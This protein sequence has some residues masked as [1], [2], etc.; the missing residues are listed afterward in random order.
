MVTKVFFSGLPIGEDLSEFGVFAKFIFSPI[1]HFRL[2]PVTLMLLAIQAVGQ[3]TPE[4]KVY[5]V[6]GPPCLLK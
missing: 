1:D 3:A 5:L 4:D 6:I 2:V